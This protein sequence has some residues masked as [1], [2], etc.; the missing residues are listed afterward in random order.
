[1]KILVFSHCSVVPRYRRRFELLAAYPGVA[2]VTVVIPPRWQEGG[3][4]VEGIAECSANY[5]VRVERAAFSSGSRQHAHYYPEARSIVRDESPDL[6]FLDEEPHSFVTFHLAAA[7]P[8]DV[9][10]VFAT[11]QN[12]RKGIRQDGLIRAAAYRVFRRRAFR[13]CCAA[14]AVGHEAADLLRHSG[15]RG[16]VFVLPIIGY[17]ETPGV[18]DASAPVFPFARRKGALV[19]GFAGRLIPQKGPDV[20]LRASSR[21]PAVRL[22]IAGSGPLRGELERL[23]GSLG[24]LGRVAFVGPVAPG[25]MGSFFRGIDVLVLPSRP[26]RQ[27]VEQY[28]RVLVEAMAEGAVPVGS[29]CG[30]IPHVIGDAGL[31]FPAGDAPALALA[32]G[33]LEASSALLADCSARARER[34]ARLYS[35]SRI[36]QGYYL[37]FRRVLG[38][39]GTE[40]VLA[41]PNPVWLPDPAAG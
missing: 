34:A 39:H 20:L 25:H 11:Y 41:W 13:R 38:M 16:A 4:M 32:L 3:G 6:V 9:P 26:H 15:F 1:M 10:L 2:H 24:L 23:A 36:A 21:L 14:Q 35:N 31:T 37:A 28:G 19:A 33:G 5:R 29:D 17:D 8:P 18:D 30:E 40:P 27:W 7:V 22:M 12:L